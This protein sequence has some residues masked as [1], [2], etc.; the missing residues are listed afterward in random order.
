MTTHGA[1]SIG[2]NRARFYCHP[3]QKSFNNNQLPKH[4]F[5]VKIPSNGCRTMIR[6]P[7]KAAI[8]SGCPTTESLYDLLGI[9]ET[10][11]LM[12][13]K[14]AYKQLV[15]K[16]HPDVSPPERVEEHTKRFIQVQEAYEILSDRRSRA[17]YD[18]DLSRGLHVAFP[19]IKQYHY[20]EVVIF[21]GFVRVHLY[22]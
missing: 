18:R 16:Y 21:S 20:R 22:V 4:I 12:E 1:I 15:R 19:S 6:S 17:L 8:S 10:G 14:Q 2:A 9:S 3:S 7:P 5:S 13:I 11:T